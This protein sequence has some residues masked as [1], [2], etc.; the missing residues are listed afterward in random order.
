MS[1]VD[2][3]K[4]IREDKYSKYNLTAEQVKQIGDD[5]GIN[6]DEVDFGEFIQGV[7]EELEHG[8]M[9][10]IKASDTNVTSDDLNMTAKIAWAH[11]KEVPDYYTRLEAME[12]EGEEHWEKNSYQEWI[13]QNREKNADIWARFK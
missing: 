1:D 3:Y 11:L 5:I 13:K 4:K 6:W 8:D 12:G 7:K 10:A 2:F 9:F